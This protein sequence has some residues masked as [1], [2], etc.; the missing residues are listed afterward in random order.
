[1]MSSL[2]TFSRTL[3]IPHVLCSQRSKQSPVHEPR[4]RQPHHV[5]FSN[6]NTFVVHFAQSKDTVPTERG[7]C[8]GNPRR[9]INEARRTYTT[10]QLRSEAPTHSKNCVSHTELSILA[11]STPAQLRFWLSSHRAYAVSFSPNQVLY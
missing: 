6:H 11:I 10:V 1:M 3:N 8:A 4:P 7:V 2:F 5:T 9:S